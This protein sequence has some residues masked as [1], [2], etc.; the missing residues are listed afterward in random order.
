MKLQLL[1]TVSTHNNT[2]PKP[3]KAYNYMIEL[4][5]TRSATYNDELQNALSATG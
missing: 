5:L 1:Y 4:K 2:G 3:S